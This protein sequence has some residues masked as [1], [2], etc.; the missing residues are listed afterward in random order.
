MFVVTKVED[1]EEE[2]YQ[3]VRDQ[4]HFDRTDHFSS[5]FLTQ[6]NVGFMTKTQEKDAARVMLVFMI[7]ASQNGVTFKRLTT[8]GKLIKFLFNKI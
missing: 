6:K 3:R 2:S 7:I 8:F 5:F 1:Q 4:I